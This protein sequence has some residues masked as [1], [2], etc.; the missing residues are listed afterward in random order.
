MAPLRWDA[1]G[2]DETETLANDRTVQGQ[3][4]MQLRMCKCARAAPAQKDV[5]VGE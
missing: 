1:D 5:S 4:H 2:C 3:S